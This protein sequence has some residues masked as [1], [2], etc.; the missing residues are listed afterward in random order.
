MPTHEQ[1]EAYF[2]D[3]S[4]CVFCGS[5]QLEGDAITVENGTCRQPMRCLECGANW[6]D[7]YT[8]TTAYNL[9]SGE[10]EPS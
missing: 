4:R 5:D 8:L 1:L 7:V 2:N 6:D 10:E 9:N 3:P